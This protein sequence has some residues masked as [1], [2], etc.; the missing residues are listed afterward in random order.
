MKASVRTWTVCLGRVSLGAISDDR[1]LAVGVLADWLPYGRKW[2]KCQSAYPLH[3][4]TPR[5]AEWLGGANSSASLGL[6]EFACGVLRTQIVLR[7]HLMGAH[8]IGMHLVG[9][10]RGI[11]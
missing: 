4:Q 2:V 5:P 9:V 3:G 6:G 11:S 10:D 8:L 1:E 7:W